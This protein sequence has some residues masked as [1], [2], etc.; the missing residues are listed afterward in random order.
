MSGFSKTQ[1]NISA[2]YFIWVLVVHL[3]LMKLLAY[4]ELSLLS[5]RLLPSV[6]FAFLPFLT[7]FDESGVSL[8]PFVFSVG[9]IGFFM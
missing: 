5:W 4:L 9:L 6:P 3:I 2:F 7:I 8:F 1:S